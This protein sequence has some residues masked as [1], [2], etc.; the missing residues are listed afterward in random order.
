MHMYVYYSYIEYEN[1]LFESWK[2]YLKMW[3]VDSIKIFVIYILILFN[4][5]NY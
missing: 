3:I 2:L 1:F 4:S 5:E